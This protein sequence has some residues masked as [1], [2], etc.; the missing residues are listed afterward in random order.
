[1]VGAAFQS[2]NLRALIQRPVNYSPLATRSDSIKGPDATA[3][4]GRWGQP[5]SLVASA[6]GSNPSPVA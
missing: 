3:L 4:V 5:Q 6:R 1:M 2:L